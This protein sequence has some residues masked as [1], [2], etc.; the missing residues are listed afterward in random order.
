MLLFLAACAQQTDAEP[1][2]VSSLETKLCEQYADAAERIVNGWYPTELD[3]TGFDGLIGVVLPGPSVFTNATH[4]RRQCPSPRPSIEWVCA[5]RALS[6]RLGL[7]TGDEPD[8]PSVVLKD[9]LSSLPSLGLD[10]NA[11]EMKVVVELQSGRAASFDPA[12]SD[13]RSVAPP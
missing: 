2:G 6:L 13:E 3:C 9:I 7:P 1:K 4:A 8:D 11:D 10:P 12:S 5:P